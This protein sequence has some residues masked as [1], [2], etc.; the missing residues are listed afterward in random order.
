MTKKLYLILSIPLFLVFCSHSPVEEGEKYSIMSRYLMESLSRYH[1]KAPA[2]NDEF[3]EKAYDEYIKRLDFGKRFL[4]QSDIDEL[5][6]YK[7]AVDDQVKSGNFEFYD[8]SVKKLNE[9]IE[10]VIAFYTEI[11]EKP[12]DYDNNEFIEVDPEKKTFA[13]DLDELKDSWRKSL[14]YEA[15]G[16]IEDKIE[17][18]EKAKENK[19]TT[20]E[21]KSFDQIE[22][23]IRKDLA[24][25]YEEMF[26]R[27]AKLKDDDRFSVYI[28]SILSVF[29][30]HTQYFPPKDKEDFDIRMS[31]KLEGIGAQLSQRDEYIRV[32]KIIIGSPSWKQGELKD[33]DIILKV[34]QGDDEPID[35]VDM[36]LDDAVRLIRGEKGTEVRL[37][38]KKAID[39]S[40]VVIPIIR[41]VVNLED[42]F[43]KSVILTEEGNSNKIGYVYL[44]AFY[45]DFKDMRS[46]RS[47]T[48]MK[49]EIEKLSSEGVNG[50]ILDLRTNGGGSLQDAVDI[51]GLFIEKGPVVQVYS[52]MERPQVLQDRDPGQAWKGPLVILVSL[53]SASASEILSAAMQDYGRAII[54]GSK[55][56]YGKGTVQR[57]LDFDEMIPGSYDDLKP[58]GSLKLTIQKFYRINGGSTQ[59]KGVTPDIIL[60]DHYKYIDMGEK[61]LDFAMPWSQVPPAQYE[62]LSS[63]YFKSSSDF[64]SIINHSYDRIKND[65]AWSMVDD[66][67]KYLKELRDNTKYTLNFKE[68]VIEDKKRKDMSKKF[69]N[70]GKDTLNIKI[71][72][73]KQDLK[74]IKSDSTNIAQREDWHKN[75]KKDRA[76][77]EAMNVMNDIIELRNY[78]K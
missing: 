36:R 52:S 77:F 72:D 20:I 47:S 58:F 28:N 73:L 7:L 78:I 45:V 17:E 44:P 40:Q 27:I 35:V 16:R 64:S 4:I 32:E 26:G 42:A 74:E 63:M 41:D 66:Y 1:F 57:F 54:I 34:A 51:A 49:L 13:K 29:D 23:D 68:F 39:G 22:K 14:K 59:L 43:A 15:I 75:L 71:S 50:I 9:R 30:P 11:L 25:R 31:G 37:T 18:Q 5:S 33:G 60:P 67:A 56:T 48:D 21:I 70:I 69:E 53:S 24:K 65:T 6:K 38:V 55:S 19:D 10:Q 3:S 2:I 46:R 76:L 62:N 8:I 61:E 12:F